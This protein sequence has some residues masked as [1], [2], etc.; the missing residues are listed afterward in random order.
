MSAGAS[1]EGRTVGERGHALQAAASSGS[2]PAAPEPVDA[3]AI[4]DQVPGIVWT[5]DD[6]LRIASIGG[7]GL[8][9]A[10]AAPDRLV[11]TH[12]SELVGAGDAADLAITAHRRALAGSASSYDTVFGGLRYACHVAPLRGSGREVVGAIGVAVDAPA[13]TAAEEA[14]RRSEQRLRTTLE[15]IDAIVSFRPRGGDTA[16]LSPQ[17]EAI[18]GYP[19]ESISDLVAWN[20][21]VHPD[22]LPTCQR[23]WHS[24]SETWEIEYRMRRADGRWIWVLDRGRRLPAVDETGP[25]V[26]A[27]IVDVTERHEAEERLRESERQL[28][29]RTLELEEAREIAGLGV[30]HRDLR[31]GALSWSPQMYR[32]FGL[33]P[34]APAPTREVMD[35]AFTAE[36]DARRKAAIARSA[37]TGE[38]WEEELEVRRPDGESRWMW[39]RGRAEVDGDGVVVGYHG[40]AIDVTERRETLAGL[41]RLRAAIEQAGEAIVITD[42]RAR[43]VFAN[44]AFGR[45]TGHVPAETIG[46]DARDLG[47]GPDDPSLAEPWWTAVAAGGTWEG[48]FPSRRPDGTLYRL[49]MS[50]T[51]VRDDAGT[52]TAYVAVGWDITDERAMEARLRQAERLEVVGRLAGGIAHDF[53]NLLT[54]ISGYGETARSSLPADSPARDD[55]DQVLEAAARAAALTRQLLA[56]SRRQVLEPRTLDPAAVIDRLAPLLRRLLGEHIELTTEH[57]PG[58]GWVKVDAGQ[59]EQVIVNLA[60][61]ARDA[62]PDGGHLT[63]RSVDILL[64]G[65][66]PAAD[67]DVASGPYRRITVSDTGTGMEP[68]TLARIFEPFF[69]TKGSGLG[70]GMGL[71]PVYGIV[72]QSG[73]RI[74]CTSAPGRGTTFTIDLPRVRAPVEVAARPPQG[75]PAAAPMLTGTETLLVVED[76]RSVRTYLVRVLRDL[77]YTVLAAASG[78]EAET[79]AADPEVVIDLVVTDVRMPGIQGPELARR[80]REGRP[81]V[82]VLFVSGYAAEIVAD[83]LDAAGGHVLTKPVDP[84]SLARGVRAVLDERD[85]TSNDSPSR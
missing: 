33:D 49:E 37:A 28:H 3:G 61:N 80:I 16:V 4:V 12:I 54:A 17:T 39:Q 55:I 82:P 45:I 62:M 20:A 83:S 6:D 21:V 25:G 60:V 46:R 1:G 67:P 50:V 51:P 35:A 76:E 9:R 2:V 44:A 18:L 10:G 52:V 69:T 5:V 78:A 30:F 71:A 75:P 24:P 19:P 77:G 11:G 70:S 41:A 64:E 73:G 26:I 81:D 74:A 40:T 36:S 63:I 23:A 57:G 29:E 42:G 53:N 85:Q 72:E 7:A 31:T 58:P 43:V 66:D 79:I 34:A 22:D 27:V 8:G 56:F 84:T 65:A 38:P 68:G 48:E 15:G 14:L 13:W 47:I 32:I 59:L